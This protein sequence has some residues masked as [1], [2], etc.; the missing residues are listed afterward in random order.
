MVN[1]VCRNICNSS[2][3]ERHNNELNDWAERAARKATDDD[4]QEYMR[5]RKLNLAKK[6]ERHANV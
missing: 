6:D 1:A 4:V 5:Q 3:V 2:H